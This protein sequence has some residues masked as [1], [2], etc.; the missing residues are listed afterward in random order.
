MGLLS[1][2]IVQEGWPRIAGGWKPPEM[3]GVYRSKKLRT[4]SSSVWEGAA[5]YFQFLTAF[6]AFSTRM[7]LPPITWISAT[8]PLGSTVALRRTSPSMCRLF[9]VWG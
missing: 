9:K 7:G 8:D 6:T 1:D 5:A 4:T 3:L 2:P